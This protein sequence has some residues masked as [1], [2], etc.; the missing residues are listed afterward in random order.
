M[1]IKVR[2]LGWY[3]ME[4]IDIEIEDIPLEALR[5]DD[6]CAPNIGELCII[7]GKLNVVKDITFKEAD[8]LFKATN[9]YSFENDEMKYSRGMVYRVEVKQG[10]KFIFNNK[11]FPH[12]EALDGRYIDMIAQKKPITKYEY[13]IYDMK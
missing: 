11:I 10:C 7:N 5:V 2:H 4:T 1:K 3:G 12:Q 13:G 9:M 8:R 6:W